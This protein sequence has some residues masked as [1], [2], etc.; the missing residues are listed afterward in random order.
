MHDWTISSNAL[1]VNHSL[2]NGDRLVRYSIRLLNENFHHKYAIYWLCVRKINLSSLINL[3]RRLIVKLD[4]YAN[5]RT[6]LGTVLSK[7]RRVFHVHI[8]L[9]NR[10]TN[11]Y[12]TRYEIR[13]Y[14]TFN[15]SS[16][17]YA[18]KW[19]LNESVCQRKQTIS[20]KIALNHYLCYAVKNISSYVLNF[21]KRTCKYLHYGR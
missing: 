1:T 16:V 17:E 13:E 19:Y 12:G 7:V 11:T 18:I 14:F 15:L 8:Q 20:A 2:S 9:I 5:S 6:F 21:V 4:Y 10:E 3:L